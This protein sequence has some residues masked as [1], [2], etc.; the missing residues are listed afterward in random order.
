MTR[1]KHQHFTPYQQLMFAE[2]SA[3]AAHRLALYS[4]KNE[5]GTV[6]PTSYKLPYKDDKHWRRRLDID[7]WMEPRTQEGRDFQKKTD[8]LFYKDV[9]LPKHPNTYVTLSIC[10]MIQARLLTDKE[11]MFTICLLQPSGMNKVSTWPP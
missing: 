8:N 6:R 9:D 7:Y 3:R 1:V 5:N 10:K 4:F 11:K 2:A